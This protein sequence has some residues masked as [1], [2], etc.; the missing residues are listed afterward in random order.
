MVE[1]QPTSHT[2][3]FRVVG[4]DVKFQH[5]RVLEDVFTPRTAHL[6]VVVNPHVDVEQI[7]VLELLVARAALE[8]VSSGILVLFDFVDLKRTGRGEALAAMRAHPHSED[9]KSHGSVSERK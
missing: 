3:R 1:F 4:F 6:H 5:V 9:T 7:R 2:D 8:H